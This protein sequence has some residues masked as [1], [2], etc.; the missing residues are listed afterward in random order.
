VAKGF[1]LAPDSKREEHA[2]GGKSL[3][4]FHWFRGLDLV[5][6]LK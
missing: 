6:A 1:I 5:I 2:F 4:F 3:E